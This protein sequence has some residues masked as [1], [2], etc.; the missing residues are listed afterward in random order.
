M[1]EDTT[2]T[3]AEYVV[4]AEWS[5]LPERA[6]RETLRA[7]VNFVGCALGG[8]TH[9]GFPIAREAA[10]VIGGSPQASVLGVTDVTDM[11]NAA[12]LNCYSSAVHTFDDT[13]LAS[14][15]HPTGPAAAAALAVAEHRGIGGQAFLNAV[16]LGIETVC[17]VGTA[18]MVPPAKADINLF[19]TGLAG[20]FGAAAAA[21]KLMNLDRRKMIYALGI[22]AAQA[23]GIREMHGTMCSGFVPAQAARNGLWA[24]LLAEKGF[25]SSQCGLEGSKGFGA[26]FGQPANYDAITDGLG[27]HFELYSNAIKAYPCG[28]VIHSVIDACLD[29]A[30]EE[31]YDSASVERCDLRVHPVTIELTGRKAPQTALAAQVSLYHWAAAALERGVAGLPEGD[32]ASVHDPQ[33]LAMRDRITAMAA[34]D[35]TAGE[36]SATL[37]FSDG[38]TSSVRVPHCRGSLERPMTDDE[39]DRKFRAQAE[40]ILGVEASNALLERSWGCVDI[41][42]MGVVG[43]L[44]RP[45]S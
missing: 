11:A 27:S 34:D 41:A 22:A 35:H 16:Y 28:I 20:T 6:Q 10:T 36:T 3:L 33:I 32:D 43:D 14:I 5:D 26:V 44:A 7:F 25:D 45:A 1:T 21:G 42:R 17:R 18:L 13:H 31:G 37:T 15:V 40:P 2:A 12:F 39:I 23:A 30:R 24:A 38:R 19:M 9:P 4:G 8:S 29:L